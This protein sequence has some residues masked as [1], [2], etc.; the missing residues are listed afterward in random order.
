MKFRFISE[1]SSSNPADNLAPSRNLKSKHAVTSELA[2][3]C[4]NIRKDT[5]LIEWQSDLSPREAVSWCRHRHEKSG[6]D[7]PDAFMKMKPHTV[8]LSKEALRVLP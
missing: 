7:I 2:R 1:G 4:Q 6:M 3:N 8:P 5:L